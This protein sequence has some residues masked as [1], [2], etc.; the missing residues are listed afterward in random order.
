MFGEQMNESLIES[1]AGEM[2]G[3]F[4]EHKLNRATAAEIGTLSLDDAYKVQ[5]RFLA[6]RFA[7]GERAAGYKIGCTSPAIRTQFG[8]SEP[9]CAR[10]TFPRI[11]PEGVTLN[12]DDYVDCA[13]EPELVL[14]IGA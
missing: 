7:N 6:S 1:F 11:Y 9:I 14:H 12:I 10:L 3:I 13:L 8:L 5:E 4:R 2:T